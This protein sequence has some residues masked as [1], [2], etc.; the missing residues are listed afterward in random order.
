MKSV[1]LKIKDGAHGRSSV[2]AVSHGTIGISISKPKPIN[3]TVAN[4]GAVMQLVARAKRDDNYLVIRDDFD[5]S[6]I[7][8]AKHVRSVEVK[9]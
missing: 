5:R 2:L 9:L 4:I 1:Q 3:L 7:V 8:F 6:M